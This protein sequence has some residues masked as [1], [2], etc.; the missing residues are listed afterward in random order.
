MI[1]SGLGYAQGGSRVAN[2]IGIGYATTDPANY[3]GALTVPVAQQLTN[4][5]TAHGSF[6]ANQLVIV[7]GGANDI[8]Y[9]L[10]AVQTG[11]ITP[12][13]ATAAIGQAAIDLAGV[14]GK[15][16]QSGAT[17]VLVSNVPDIGTT[18]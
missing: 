9:N 18:P 17:H 2:P 5:L 12:A 1:Q 4:Y 8:L 16:L 10:Q 6:N 3:T 7:N 13:Q 14:I 11:A 15:I